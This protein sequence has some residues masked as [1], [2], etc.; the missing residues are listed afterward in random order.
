MDHLNG[1]NKLIMLRQNMPPS[2]NTRPEARTSLTELK[3]HST[4]VDYFIFV[5]AINDLCRDG[6][7]TL[8]DVK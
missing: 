1:R 4:M 5:T 7:Y 6:A 2:F 3:G 8:L